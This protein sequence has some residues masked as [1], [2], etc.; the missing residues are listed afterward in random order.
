MASPRPPLRVVDPA[1][2]PD[3][4]FDL[5]FREH[6]AFVHRTLCALGVDPGAVD[7]A[8]QEVFMVVHRRLA[9]YDGRV[10]IRGWIFGIT[11]RVAHDVRRSSQRRRARIALVEE[12]RSVPTPEHQLSQRHAVAFIAGFLATL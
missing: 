1:G 2:P 6:Y 7:D 3:S 10:P 12:P 11:R 9:D 5:A 4:A 8:A